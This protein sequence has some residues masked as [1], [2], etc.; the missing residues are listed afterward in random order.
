MSVYLFLVLICCFCLAA[1][2]ITATRPRLAWVSLI[3]GS[4]ITT[5]LMPL[6]FTI[7]DELIIGSILSGCLI[8]IFL[9]RETRL[10][11]DPDPVARL[12]LIFFTFLI[13]YLIF[14]STRGMIILSSPR[15]I[16]WVL[17]FAMVGL[18]PILL[19]TRGF[20]LPSRNQT[21][22]SILVSTLVYQLIYVHTGI[23]AEHILGLTRWDLQLTWWGTSAY[24]MLPVSVAVPAVL[25]SMRDT[26]SNTRFLGYMTLL[27]IIISAFYY[28]SRVAIL[29]IL[30]F[31]LVS[32]PR[33]GFKKFSFVAAVF[34]TVFLIFT[35]SRNIDIRFFMSDLVKSVYSP[36]D[37]AWEQNKIGDIDRHAH[38][39]VSVT[40]ISS[41]PSTLLFGH[42]FRQHGWIISQHLR[43]FYYAHH[44]PDIARRVKDDSSTEGFTALIV[45]TGIVGLFLLGAN[46]FLLAWRIFR[47][48][49]G[50]DGVILVSAI[51]VLFLWL[52]VINLLDVGVYYIA[53]MPSGLLCLL[54]QPNIRPGT[55]TPHHQKNPQS[56]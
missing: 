47:Q 39:H 34:L 8:R 38:I 24:T 50:W 7:V 56:R 16:R 15:K 1:T 13:G 21:I 9:S 19:N 6:G 30:G 23:F 25:L 35:L 17:F 49:I 5:G 52:F 54:A 36:S 10:R 11:I 40:S 48:K 37:S 2:V 53:I 3:S 4:I 12:H 26:S 28:D 42:G 43:S 45:D 33:I 31:F 51:G 44:R 18:L 55:K 22:T 32:F 46:L 29:S 27:A 14:Q 41:D 20:I